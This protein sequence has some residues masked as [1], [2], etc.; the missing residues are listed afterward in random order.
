MRTR[1]I[2]VDGYIASESGCLPMLLSDIDSGRACATMQSITRRAVA[3]RV[4]LS[5]LLAGIA[6]SGCGGASSNGSAL[7]DAEFVARANAVCSA[8]AAR[9]KPLQ[10]PTDMPSMATY[11]AEVLP[12]AQEARAKL[13]ALTPPSSKQTEYAHLLDLGG[14]VISKTEELRGAAEAN[15]GKRV[16][17]LGNDVSGLGQEENSAA[18]NLGLTECAHNGE[19]QGG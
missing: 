10:Q 17:S 4:A 9:L 8:A 1:R 2:K 18:T 14:Q 16:Q 7:S 6:L 19:T 13:A 5:V 12:I 11:M 3:H 15:E